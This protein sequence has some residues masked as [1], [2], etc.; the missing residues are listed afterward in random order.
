MAKDTAAR[1]SGNSGT[2]KK[3]SPLPPPESAP[4]GPLEEEIPKDGRGSA[5][6]PAGGSTPDGGRQDET[7]SEETLKVLTEERPTRGGRK[8]GL[9]DADYLAALLTATPSLRA[10]FFGNPIRAIGKALPPAKYWDYQE[11][12]TLWLP[13]F[14]YQPLRYRRA[15]R[16]LAKQVFNKVAGQVENQTLSSSINT[17]SVFDEFF[18]PIVRASQRSYTSVY[19]LSWAAFVIGM[20]L[21][22]V[23]TYIGIHPPKGVNGTTVASV[24]GGSGAVSALG[25]VFGMAV[26]SIRQATSDLA[27]V[28]VVLTAFA[29]QLG[30]LRAQ[31]EGSST[32]TTQPTFGSVVELNKAIGEAMGSAIT[33]MAGNGSKPVNGAQGSPDAKAG[34]A[35]ATPKKN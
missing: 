17:D 6:G 8:P 27:R 30:Q 5:A 9:T 7:K 25:S 22:G 1:G 23:G 24:F 34:Q 10:Q 16:E 4:A 33:S 12:S 14:W 13:W 21:I 28:R 11:G 15:R 26:S 19:V 3:M 35:P 29:T 32:S 18:S 20:G 31:F 2:R